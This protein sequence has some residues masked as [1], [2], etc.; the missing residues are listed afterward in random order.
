VLTVTEDQKAQTPSFEQWRSK[1]EQDFKQE[2]AS[3]MLP[4]KTQELADR[5]HA[6]HDLKKAAKELGATVKTSELVTMESQVPDIGSMSGP[7]S[8]AFDM[9]AGEISNA[10]ENGGS[11][12]VFAVIDKQQPSPSELAK[13][14]EQVRERLLQQKREQR[15]QMFIADVRDRMQKDGKIRINKDEWSRLTGGQN[16]PLAG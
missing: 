9:K 7:A 5:A 8:V 6:E 3:Q 15:L 12:V 10:I 14:K 13:T 11:G 2:R 1:V 16:I 4:Q